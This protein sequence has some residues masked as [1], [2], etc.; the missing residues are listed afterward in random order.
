MKRHSTKRGLPIRSV[1]LAKSPPVVRASYKRIT[2]EVQAA[3]K[4]L[5][6]FGGVRTILWVAVGLLLVAVIYLAQSS[7]AAMVAYNLRVK[8]ARIQQLEQENAQ[9]R[10]EISSMTAPSA[11]EARAKKLG[12][13]P[14]RR[15]VYADLPALQGDPELN[16]AELP[17]RAPDV[18]LQAAVQKTDP[19]H[20]L[21]GV[22]GLGQTNRAEAQS[23]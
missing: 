17:A 23:Q 9:L 1:V 4:Q 5:P 6:T 2:Q 3:L 16:I 7:N 8:E 19:W 21:L 18:P 10:Y 15:A 12:L 14:A 11:I 22:F 20:D 13:G